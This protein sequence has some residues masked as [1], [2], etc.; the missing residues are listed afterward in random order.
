MGKYFK[1]KNYFNMP[2]QILEEFKAK[3]ITL[4]ADQASSL[5]TPITKKVTNMNEIGKNST[6][7]HSPIS[8]FQPLWIAS[9]AS[10]AIIFMAIRKMPGRYTK[11]K[12][13]IESKTNSNRSCCGTCNWIWS[14]MDCR[15]HGRIKHFEFHGYSVVLIHYTF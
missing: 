6:N 12:L 1:D 2:T 14:Y 11:R 13:C 8:L 4:I 9:L 10:A 3:G 5:V 7:G 15:W